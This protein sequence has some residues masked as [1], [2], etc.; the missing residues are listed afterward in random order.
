MKSTFWVADGKRV[1][2]GERRRAAFRRARLIARRGGW[3][4]VTQMGRIG[5]DYPLAIAMWEANDAVNDRKL[6]R[7]PVTA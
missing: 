6:R 3:V 2:T 5:R 7:V 4:L 1:R